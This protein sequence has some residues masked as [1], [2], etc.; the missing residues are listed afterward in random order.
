MLSDEQIQAVQRIRWY[1]R[2]ELGDGVVTPGVDDSV[3][4]FGRIRMPDDL[5]GKSVLDIGAWDGFYSF[6]AERRGARR[7]LATD[8]YCWSGPGWGSQDGFNLARKILHSRVEDQEIDVMELAPERIGV[9]D[10]V[11]LLGVLYHMRY[12]MLALDRVASVTGELLIV[13]TQ[14]DMID[15]PRPALA[16]Y[17]GMELEQDPTNWFAP[18]PAAMEGMLRAVGFQRVEMVSPPD[19]V[20]ATP[21]QVVSRAAAFHAWK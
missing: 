15:V 12:P 8:S 19:L 1:H 21:E 3:A 18:N 4:T 5:T 13:S 16:F 2:I 20:E 9:F 14:V 6:E 11:L 7:V 10:V 17:P